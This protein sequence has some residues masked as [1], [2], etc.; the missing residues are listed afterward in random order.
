M[1][2]DNSVLEPNSARPG[3]RLPCTSMCLDGTKALVSIQ[4]KENRLFPAARQTANGARLLLF[5]IAGILCF[6]LVL[7]VAR[8]AYDTS[9]HTHKHRRTQQTV[10]PQRLKKII[11]QMLQIRIPF[12]TLRVCFVLSNDGLCIMWGSFVLFFP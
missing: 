5:G 8:T 1:F 7:N 2:L 10:L 3:S 9:A 11:S 4:Y 12:P 6:S